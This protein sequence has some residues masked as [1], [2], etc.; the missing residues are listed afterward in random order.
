MCGVTG[1]LYKKSGSQGLAPVGED[2]IKMLESMTHR[3]KDSS[4]LT[5]VGE[6]VE[7]DLV[8]RIWTGDAALAASSPTLVSIAEEASG[9]SQ[10]LWAKQLH[11][12]G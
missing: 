8:I 2:L 4:G 5:V 10:N 11:R 3:G 12:P 1:I 9:Q 7:G 6:D